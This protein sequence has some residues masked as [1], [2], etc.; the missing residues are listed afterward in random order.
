MTDIASARNKAGAVRKALIIAVHH[1]PF[2]TGTHSSS[3]EMLADIDETCKNANIMPDVVLAAHS[4]NYQR[5]T[6]YY[7]FNG[8]NMQI[9]FVVCG[10][11]GRAVENVA[12]ATGIR[13]GDHSFDK[14]AKTY[15]YLKLT[16]DPGTVRIQ[17]YEVM[18]DS[19]QIFDDITVD[20]QT[21]KMT[22]Q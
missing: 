11:G 8:V 2:S 5:Y 16:V 15:G 18:Q 13:T 14:S 20:L 9:P 3:S 21:N 12:P 1:P 6:R 10:C 17:F 19:K 7:P 22:S 4:H